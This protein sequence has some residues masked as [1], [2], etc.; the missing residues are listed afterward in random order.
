MGLKTGH[1]MTKALKTG[2]G[3]SDKA[4]RV[5]RQPP[6]WGALGGPQLRPEWGA[7]LQRR[8]TLVGEAP[9][10]SCSESSLYPVSLLIPLL[11]AHQEGHRAS[12]Q[13]VF[14]LEAAPPAAAGGDTR[15]RQRRWQSSVEISARARRASAQGPSLGPPRP[16]ARRGGGPRPV[17]PRARPRLPRQDAQARSE[18]GGSEHSAECASLFH[19]TIAETSEDEDQASDHTASRFGDGESSGSDV[20]GGVRASGNHLAWP[21]A[22][23]HHPPRAAAGSRPP[24]PPVPKLCR[25]KASKA[26]KKKIRRFQ[27]AALKVM[28]MV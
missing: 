15:R 2:R 12:A 21:R 11:V 22:A 13:A 26:L 10:R 16:A 17:C 18:S 28:T 6:P 4:L 3:T 20:E 25:I 5:G 23:P 1:P 8:P 9:G 7:G 19:S 24:L 27:P 14:P